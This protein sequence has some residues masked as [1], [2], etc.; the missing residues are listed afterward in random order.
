MN[1]VP[2]SELTYDAPAGSLSPL[3]F[4]NAKSAIFPIEVRALASSHQ[5]TS[6]KYFFY[7][8]PKTENRP[9]NAKLSVGVS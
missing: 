5:T 9:V 6:R 2:K 7:C 4:R 8:S 1:A 3:V